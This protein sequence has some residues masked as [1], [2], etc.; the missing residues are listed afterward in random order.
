MSAK[1]GFLRDDETEEDAA[2]HLYEMNMDGN[3]DDWLLGGGWDHFKWPKAELPSVRSLDRFFPNRK[4]FILNKE[5]HGAWVNSATLKYFEINKNTP[6][7][8]FGEFFR[9]SEGNPT[10][11]L[12]ELAAI[13]VLERIL[14]EIPTETMSEYVKV[15]EQLA[16]ANGI[17]SVSDMQLSGLS[18]YDIYEQMEKNGNLNLRVHYYAPFKWDI[19]KLLG[20]KALH[21]SEILKFGGTKEFVDGT[22]MGYTGLMCEPYSNRPDFYGES[23]IDLMYLDDK[24]SR[25]DA[26][27]I[28][29]RLHCCGDRA[30]K[31]A[32]DSFENAISKNG[33]RDSRHSIEHI[34][35]IRPQDILRFGELGVIA[36]VQ[37]E[38]MPKYDF[39]NH[40]FHTMLGEERIR[41]SWPFNSLANGGGKLAFGS[42]FCVAELNPMRGVFRAVTRLTN[43]LEPTN[44]FSPP[45]RLV[46]AD[47][48]RAYTYGSAYVNKREHDLGTLESGKLADIV[49][50]DRNIFDIP[51]EELIYVKVDVTM[52]NGNIVYESN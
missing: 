2:K 45:E 1:G 36:S 12:H 44:G 28:D 30:V 22:P 42:D 17:T 35:S 31:E 19:E 23:A 7:P 29:V 52:F 37:P 40:P 10:G 4:V 14:D 9:D 27:G 6:D 20:L 26:F 8:E 39:D 13:E 46:L 41:W 11:Y 50:L 18:S 33:R 24:I 48:L 25:L 5:C 47:A 34:E 16:Y 3:E 43:D 38:H 15:F 32:L 51:G 21:N 49:V